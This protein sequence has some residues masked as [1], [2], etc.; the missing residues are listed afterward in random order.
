MKYYFLAFFFLLNLNLSAQEK[1][2]YSSYQESIELAE[3]IYQKYLLYSQ[4]DPGIELHTFHIEGKI[5]DEHLENILLYLKE[6]N[7]P[8]SSSFL[9]KQDYIEQHQDFIKYASKRLDRRMVIS[10]K[11]FP[12]KTPLKIKLKD[13]FKQKVNQFFGTPKGLSFWSFFKKNGKRVNPTKRDGKLTHG[14]KK[15]RYLTKHT[16]A[17]AAA[18]L[19]VSQAV[20]NNL[21]GSIIESFKAMNFDMITGSLAPLMTWDMMSPVIVMS[22]YVALVAYYARELSGFKNQGNALLYRP[23]SGQSIKAVKSKLFYY[24]S[25][26]AVSMAANTAV[27][28][29]MVGERFF[30]TA[31]NDIALNT[32]SNSFIGNFVKIPFEYPI[33]KIF[34]ASER[35]KLAGNKEKAKSLHKKAT[36]IKIVWSYIYS[37]LKTVHLVAPELMK[38]GIPEVQAVTHAIWMGFNIIGVTSLLFDVSKYKKNIMTLWE[39]SVKA[40]K[41]NQWDHCSHAYLGRESLFTFKKPKPTSNN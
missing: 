17:A 10:N 9:N 2:S 27:M 21:H 38:S 7:V 16:V 26:I 31:D 24:A 14:E 25:T 11:A 30:Q 4:D 22:G 13:L 18:S 29:A 15:Q 36:N 3:K 28:M 32:L 19:T 5:L 8:V 40:F 35:A 20:K 39:K 12:R 6:K 33:D 41:Y 1:V 37:S 34:Q 23:I